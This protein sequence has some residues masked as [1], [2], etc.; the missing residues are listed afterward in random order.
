VLVPATTAVE[1]EEEESTE[2]GV[3]IVPDGAPRRSCCSSG[4]V[5]LPADRILA[6]VPVLLVIVAVVVVIVL[7]RWCMS[8]SGSGLSCRRTGAERVPLMTVVIVLGVAVVVVV[9]VGRNCPDI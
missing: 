9:I 2:T 7:C 1:E 3:R 5:V 4:W 8:T 6:P